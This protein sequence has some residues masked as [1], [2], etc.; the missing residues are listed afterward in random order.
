ML[1]NIG[2]TAG[3]VWEFLNENEEAT[4]SR[5]HKKLDIP[6]KLVCMALGWLAREDKI[7]FVQEGKN[8]VVRLKQ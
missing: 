5:L 7:V 4:T 6:E 2:T 8:Q 1:E 3:Q